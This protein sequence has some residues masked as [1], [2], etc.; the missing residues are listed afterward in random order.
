MFVRAD[1]HEWLLH[2][3][4][5]SNRKDRRHEYRNKVRD[6]QAGQ[7]GDDA[8]AEMGTVEEL[9]DVLQNVC[10]VHR[11]PMRLDSAGDDR[12]FSLRSLH[13]QGAG[14]GEVAMTP[15]RMST[16]LWVIPIPPEKAKLLAC[17]MPIESVAKLK[18][19]G[20]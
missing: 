2:W 14:N 11:G 15:H 12:R 13:H 8:E 20:K 18:A 1:G 6:S 19:N 17:W 7:D 10:A 16:G 9:P 4:R 5:S 3:R